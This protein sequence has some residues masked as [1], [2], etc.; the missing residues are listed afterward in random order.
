[1]PSTPLSRPSYLRS[2]ALAAA[3]LMP[4]TIGT[5]PVHAAPT[6]R[7]VGCSLNSL[8]PVLVT[9][10]TQV[11]AELPDGQPG[12]ASGQVEEDQGPKITGS[13]PKP[14]GISEDDSKKL[15][16][17]NLATVNS[18]QAIAATLGAL[19]EPSQRTVTKAVL[20]GENGFLV[21]AVKTVLNNPT[22]GPDSSLEAKVDAGGAGSVLSIECDPEDS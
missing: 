19:A 11:V 13:I 6:I 3:I 18:E 1:M 20:E 15:A 8:A 9:P 21:W 14:R 16:A 5:I 2:L 4:L 17:L 12:G 10:E 7:V 22:S